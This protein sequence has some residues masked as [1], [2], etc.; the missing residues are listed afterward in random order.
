MVNEPAPTGALVP[1]TTVVPAG[2]TYS[3]PAQILSRSANTASLPP[4]V[5]PLVPSLVR[6]WMYPLIAAAVN[7]VPA[8]IAPAMSPAIKFATAA[9][10]GTLAEFLT[11]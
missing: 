10:T 8:S 7:A 3:A 5:R 9:V 1:V 4:A 6:V 11:R 2:R